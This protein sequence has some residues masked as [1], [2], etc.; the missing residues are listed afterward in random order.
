MRWIGSLEGWERRT[1]RRRVVED[2]AQKIEV[3]YARDSADIQAAIKAAGLQN[4][5]ELCEAVGR[6]ADAEAVVAEWKRRLSEWEATPEASGARAERV[7]LE[8]ERVALEA[9]IGEEVGGFVRDVRS[10]ESEIQR[11]E[12]EAASPAP[13]PVRPAP[14]RT[15]AGEPLRTLLDR[16]AAQMGSSPSGVGRTLAAKAS[17]ALAG[18][19]FQRLAA[20][21]VDDRGGL[22]AVVGGRPSPALTLPPA[23]RDLVYLAMKLALLEHALQ[24]TKALAVVEDAFAGLSDGARRFAARLLK[25]IARGA[26]ILHATSDAAFKEAA[27]HTA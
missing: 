21:Q 6:L 2:W 3:Q 5:G 18:L 11:L 1:R 4:L 9:R 7:R 23:D 10:I 14:V 25:Q 8:E 20:V 27:D 24:G 22:H 19:S 13:A 26:Q 12:A 17:Q 15:Q 16:A